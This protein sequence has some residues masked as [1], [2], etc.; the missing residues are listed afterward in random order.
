MTEMVAMPVTT[1]M[2]VSWLV[3]VIGNRGKR[4]CSPW[5]TKFKFQIYVVQKIM[6]KKDRRKR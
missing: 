5:L 2:I 1:Q 6:K 4:R 3:G